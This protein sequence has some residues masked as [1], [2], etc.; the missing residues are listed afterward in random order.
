[1]YIC[2]VYSSMYLIISQGKRSDCSVCWAFFMS[3]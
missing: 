1:M 2:D 3:I